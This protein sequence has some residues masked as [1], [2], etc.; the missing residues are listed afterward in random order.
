MVD[1]RGKWTLVTGASRGV[2]RQISLKMAELGSNIVVHSRNLSH[3]DDLVHEIEDF[4]VKVYAVEAELS[5]QTQVASMLDR[6]DSTVPGIDILFNN[7]GISTGYNQN[8]YGHSLE[9]F[10]ICYEVN[11][12]AVANI[13][14]RYLPDMLKR[15][16]GRIVNTTSGIKDQPEL[17]AYA[18]SKAS[19]DKFVRDFAPTLEGSGVMMNLMDPGWLRTDLGGSDAPNA[20]ETVIPGAVVGALLDDGKSGR[21]ISA[22]DYV[23][24]SVAT[25]VSKAEKYIK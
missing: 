3:T 5:D 9:A 22:Q 21:W 24:M 19:L 4:G 17:S 25:A 8:L 18:A 23:G 13:C 10:R 20:V 7:A 16:F 11:M 15:G 2:G 1:V 14:Y 6:V 12:I